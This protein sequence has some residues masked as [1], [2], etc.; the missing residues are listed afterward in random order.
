MAF[1]IRSE[2][3][4]SSRML[5]LNEKSNLQARVVALEMNFFFFVTD[6]IKNE[7]SRDF[8]DFLNLLNCNTN[9]L[10]LQIGN[11]CP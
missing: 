7:Y 9:C 3:T 4:V 1:I 10:M 6:G 8:V 5:L 11:F 2:S